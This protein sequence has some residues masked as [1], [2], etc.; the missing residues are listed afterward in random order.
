MA[1]CNDVAGAV[2]AFLG[3]IACVL[4]ILAIALV[5]IIGRPWPFD[6]V[7]DELRGEPARRANESDQ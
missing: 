4:V 2:L 5:F 3:G 7:V 1:P 6:D